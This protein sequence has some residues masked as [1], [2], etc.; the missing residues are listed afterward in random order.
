MLLDLLAHD[1]ELVFFE[2]Q[3]VVR[4]VLLIENY[5]LGVFIRWVIHEDLLF[6]LVLEVLQEVVLVQDFCELVDLATLIIKD[7]VELGD[8]G[9]A[10]FALPIDNFLVMLAIVFFKIF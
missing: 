3:G 8:V 1:H 10:Y 2:F 6:E 5:L 9:A 4:L 7:D